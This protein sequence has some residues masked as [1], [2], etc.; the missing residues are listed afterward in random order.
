VVHHGGHSVSLSANVL[1]RA[2]SETLTVQFIGPS[3][4]QTHTEVGPPPFDA[5]FIAR[6]RGLDERF[7]RLQRLLADGLLGVARP[8]RGTTNTGIAVVGAPDE[9][10]ARAWRRPLRCVGSR[11]RACSSW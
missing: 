4:L 10:A 2:P 8:T 5:L 9:A 1:S 3:G 6:A 7:A 11:D